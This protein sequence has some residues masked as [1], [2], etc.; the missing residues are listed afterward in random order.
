MPIVRKV[1]AVSGIVTNNSA[2][3]ADINS[4]HSSEEVMVSSLLTRQEN[5]AVKVLCV[6]EDGTSSEYT[7]EP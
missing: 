1:R 6:Y 7:R 4:D 2:I 5:R 3:S